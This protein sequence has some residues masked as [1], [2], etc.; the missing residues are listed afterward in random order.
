[1]IPP[2]DLACQTLFILE[3]AGISLDRLVESVDTVVEVVAGL[4]RLLE[5]LE[6]CRPQLGRSEDALQV[7]T[8]VLAEISRAGWENVVSTFMFGTHNAPSIPGWPVF[9]PA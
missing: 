9:R 4:D 7:D 8:A 1:M 5:E 3:Q 2:T 6:R